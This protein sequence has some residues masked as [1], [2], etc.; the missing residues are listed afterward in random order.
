MN[1]DE[2]GQDGLMTEKRKDNDKYKHGGT[3]KKHED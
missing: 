3:M 1:V 2:I